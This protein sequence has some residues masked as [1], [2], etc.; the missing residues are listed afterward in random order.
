MT[1]LAAVAF[2]FRGNILSL[3]DYL[4]VNVTYF[5]RFPQPQ[6]LVTEN[7]VLQEKVSILDNALM[8]S[9]SLQK[10][11]ERLRQMLVL[12]KKHPLGLIAAFVL[13]K[14]PT[15]W[16]RIVVVNR[17][18]A[19]GVSKE[20]LVID[21]EGS[22]VGKIVE[23]TPRFA[24]VMLLTDPSFKIIAR[25]KDKPIEGVYR[26]ALS[27]SGVLSYIDEESGLNVG[28]QLAISDNSVYPSG[29]FIGTVQNVGKGRDFFNSRIEI[30]VAANTVGLKDVFIVKQ[31]PDYSAALSQ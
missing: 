2:F 28:D 17:G 1:A 30:R 8:Q 12:E 24:Y 10:E 20:M 22:L 27:S 13:W 4:V 7:K 15:N 18:S 29:F 23:V 6:F 25:V 21:P 11:N 5:V 9:S 3:T 16:R 19:D 26:G 14:D 31:V